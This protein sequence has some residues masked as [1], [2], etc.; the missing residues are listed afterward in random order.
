[1]CLIAVWMSRLLLRMASIVSSH[2]AD[3]SI[4]FVAF[5]S[6]CLP[7]PAAP[8]T[9]AP[10]VPVGITAGKRMDAASAIKMATDVTVAG[11][12]NRLGPAWTEKEPKK[13]PFPE[14]WLAPEKKV[15]K[16]NRTYQWGEWVKEAGDYSSN[17]GQVCF[18]GNGGVCIDRIT[19][20]RMDNNCFTE[21]PEPPWWGAWRSA[22]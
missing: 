9:N 8:V 13:S 17:Q 16:G 11:I 15:P 14:I 21:K 2:P 18:A 6:T 10:A 20:I 19:F 22:A 1:M 3:I 12:D 5:L 7:T 4:L